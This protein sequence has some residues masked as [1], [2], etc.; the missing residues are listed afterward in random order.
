MKL[1]AGILFGAVALIAYTLIE[2]RVNQQ[3]CTVCGYRISA[4]AVNQAC[5]RC[6]APINS[7]ETD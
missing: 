4:D 1:F 5:P 6:A 3:A 7:L 2:K